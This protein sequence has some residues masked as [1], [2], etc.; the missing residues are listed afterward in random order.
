MAR[1]VS[2]AALLLEAIAGPDGIDDRQPYWL[3]PGTLL[4]SS[5]LTDFLATTASS[6]IPL[7]GIRIGILAEGFS[8]PTM[9]PH[10]SRACTSAISTL[11]ALGA[12]A[13]PISIPSHLEAGVISM[14]NVPMGGGRQCL[15]NELTGRKQLYLTD[16]MAARSSSTSGDGGKQQLSQAAF[17]ALGPGAQLLWMRHLYL[18][19]KHGAQ[20]HA[21]CANLLRKLSDDYDR[22]L[23]RVDVLVMPTLPVPPGRLFEDPAAL[24]PLERLSRNVGLGAN[25]APFNSS[26]HPALTLPVG[27]VPAQEDE[28]I[29]LPTGLQ[30]VGRKFEDGVCLKIGAAWERAV[31]WRS[32]KYGAGGNE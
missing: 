8:L 25:V 4:Y 10:I 32:V 27:F 26:G 6:P 28:G 17:D 30:I 13:I 21:K 14:L 7:A 19:A 31:D 22:A 3:S 29:L 16:R 18:S 2:D 12:E 23:A 20:L 1:T 24:G 5:N 11:I 9:N 15:L